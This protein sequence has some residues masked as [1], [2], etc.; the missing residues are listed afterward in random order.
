MFILV[1]SPKQHL[2]NDMQHSV[3]KII[4]LP[5]TYFRFEKVVEFQ[6]NLL[7]DSHCIFKNLFHEQMTQK[8]I[9]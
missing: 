4:T 1:S 8:S 3:C 6:D 2:P 9:D 7:T 5:I